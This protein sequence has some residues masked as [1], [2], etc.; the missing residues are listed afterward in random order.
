M[1]WLRFSWQGNNGLDFVERDSVHA[2]FGDMLSAWTQTGKL[3]GMAEF[4]WGNAK[5]GGKRGPAKLP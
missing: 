1:H 3:I 2:F 5:A 4:R